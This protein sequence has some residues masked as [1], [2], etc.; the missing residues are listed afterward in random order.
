MI[1]S[2]RMYD[3]KR[4]ELDPVACEGLEELSQPIKETCAMLDLHCAAT[5]AIHSVCPKCKVKLDS[6]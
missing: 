3:P 4:P 5:R 6:K 2:A 1:V